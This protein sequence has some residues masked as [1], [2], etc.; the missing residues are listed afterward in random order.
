[1]KVMG[2]LFYKEWL[3]QLALFSL[4]KTPRRPYFHFQDLQRA[5]K[6]NV[7]ILF[8]RACSNRAGGNSFTLKKGR[9][10]LDRRKKLFMRRAVELWHRLPKKLVDAQA[11]KLLVLDRAHSNLVWWKMALL[12]ARILDQMSFEDPFEPKPFC[13][14]IYVLFDFRWWSG[15]SHTVGSNPFSFCLGCKYKGI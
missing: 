9:F 15:I 12:V 14:S 11:W 3:S 1:M 10:R 13:D 8:N 4:D 6:S 2:H 7:D 5:Y